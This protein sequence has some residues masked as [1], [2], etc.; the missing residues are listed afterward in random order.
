MEKLGSPDLPKLN[1]ATTLSY[2]ETTNPS[3]ITVSDLLHTQLVGGR[4]RRN[5]Y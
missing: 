5:L 4:Y 3:T 2:H 1:S